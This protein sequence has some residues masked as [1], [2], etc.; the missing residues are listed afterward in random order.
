MIEL[1]KKYFFKENF[2]GA[3]VGVASLIIKKQE[4]E[5]VF[6]FEVIDDSIYSPY[7]QDNDDLYD[8]DTVEVFISFGGN[9]KRYYEYEL[10]PYGLRFFGVIDNPTLECPKLTKLTP[11]FKSEA[12]LTDKGYKASIIIDVESLNLDLVRI[13]CFNIDSAPN[14]TQKLYA[15]NPTLSG[16]FHKSSFFVKISQ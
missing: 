5:L 14:R 3:E 6:E 11:T 9:L 8:G 1:N 10:S 4:S 15:L 2:T 16:S 13:N 7:Q 12:Q